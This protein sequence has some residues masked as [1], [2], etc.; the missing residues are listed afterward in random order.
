MLHRQTFIWLLALCAHIFTTCSAQILASVSPNLAAPIT[1]SGRTIAVPTADQLAWQELEVGMFIHIAP[2]TWQDT[3]SDNLSTPAS[4]I[5]PDKLDTDQWCRVAQSMG[6]RYIVFVAKHEGGFCWWPTDTTDY[7]VKSSPWRAGKGD[8]M[9]DLAASCKKFDLQLGVY[10]S[11]QD[12]KHGI[13]VGGKAKNPSDQPA[14]EKLFRAQLTELLSRYGD[15][16]EVWF[17]GS[18][19]FDVGDILHTHAPNA[20]IFQGPQATIRWVGNEDGIAPETNWNAVPSKA[21]KPWG[22]YTHI[23]GTPNGDRWLP[24]ECDARIRATWFWKTD[25]LD[26]LKSLKHL[27]DMYDK[28]VGRGGVLLLNNTPDRSG[29]IPP[30][31]A[32]RSAEFGSW[33]AARY[34]TAVS[35]TSGKT[36]E[37]ITQP[38]AP[39]IID[40]IMIQEDLR[41]GQRVLRFAVDIMVNDAWLEVATGTSVGHKRIIKLPPTTIQ[42]ARLRILESIGPPAIR[43]FAVFAPPATDPKSGPLP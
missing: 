24:N 43:R 1:E 20:M 35:D 7:S 33:I 11:P 32:A 26:T 40:R 13:G 22:D 28:S 6:A 12:R 31:D 2:Q 29:L 38:S 5:N 23:H 19:T 4:A 10:L 8:V 21:D 14:Y 39:S 9:A 30:E 27:A 41:K 15:M 42:S 18:L 34:S 3:E 16:M 36:T 17:D 25:N 37:L